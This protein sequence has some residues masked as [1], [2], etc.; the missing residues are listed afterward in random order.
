MS[1][2]RPFYKAWPADFLS[3]SLSLTAEEKGVYRTLLDLMYDKWAPVPSLGAKQRQYLARMCGCST[4]SFGVIL[5]RL[6][7]LEKIDRDAMGLL[8]NGRFRQIAGD[9]SANTGDLSA[10]KTEKKSPINAAELGKNKGLQAPR[11][12]ASLETRVQSPDQD[13]PGQ[14]IEETAEQLEQAIH[15]CCKALGVDLQRSTWRSNWTMQLAQMLTEDD[16]DLAH[17]VVAVLSDRA[18][19]PGFDA[20]AVRS[21]RMFR[22]DFIRARDSRRMT[23][24]LK[25]RATKRATHGDPAVIAT[26]SD[27]QWQKHL[28]SFLILG[29]WIRSELGPSPCEDGCAAP[30]ALLIKA[31]DKWAKQGNKPTTSMVGNQMLPWR[32]TPDGVFHAPTPFKISIDPDA[33]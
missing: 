33:A 18:T 30:H 23:D 12:R 4:R 22:R 8:S 28:R 24:H 16:L 5:E 11:A 21:L 27:D 29:A 2:D 25:G 10:E 9:F 26:L 31:A 6:I 19:R 7:A 17:D 13:S 14:A 32:P 1:N 15:Q 3:G 20:E